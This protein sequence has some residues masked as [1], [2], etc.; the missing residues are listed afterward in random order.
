MINQA[1]ARELIGRDLYDGGGEKVGRIGQVFLDDESGRPE[2]VTVH[3]GLFS[4]RESFVP[5]ADAETTAEGLRVSYTKGQ[6]KDA[7]N[8]DVEGGH[9]SQQE[10]E[11]LYRHYGLNYT[12]LSGDRDQAGEEDFAA[13]TPAT[14][15]T[16]TTTGRAGEDRERDRDRG[17]DQRDRDR[18]DDVQDTA[19][20]SRASGSPTADETSRSEQRVNVGTQRV[21]TGRVRLRKYI[22]T[23]YVANT[24]P[25]AR[26][27]VRIERESVQDA[28]ADSAGSGPELSEEEYVVDLREER[29]VADK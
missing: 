17:D 12:R 18:G 1:Q 11:N 4:T 13:A 19:A 9:L 7:P 10:E 29:P 15:G 21:T 27:E 2:W 28:D 5:I 22:V 8:V 3:T 16:G 23:E 24:G 6:V 25:V 20:G 14:V 26:E